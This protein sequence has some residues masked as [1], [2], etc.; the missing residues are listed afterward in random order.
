M[1]IIDRRITLRR[2]P[3]AVVRWAWAARHE[4]GIWVAG[5]RTITRRGAVRAATRAIKDHTR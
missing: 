2:R 3:A 4:C 1:N 5:G